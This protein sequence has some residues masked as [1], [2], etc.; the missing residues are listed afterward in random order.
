L[1]TI[2]RV[3]ESSV[4]KTVSYIKGTIVCNDKKTS[5]F[6]FIDPLGTSQDT[7]N[8]YFKSWVQYYNNRK[9]A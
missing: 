1:G 5:V 3:N 4:K 8:K 7:V 9:D 6:Y 2:A